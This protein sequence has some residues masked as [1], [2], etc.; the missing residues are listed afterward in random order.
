MRNIPH[1]VH[2]LEH[3]VP[4]VKLFGE[5]VECLGGGALL[6][7]RMSFEAGLRMYSPAHFQFS[8][9]PVCSADVSSQIPAPATMPPV[10]ML[11]KSLW[12]LVLWN[13]KLK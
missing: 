11:L 9:H 10:A 8:L 5:M 3:L 12:T 6:E 13:C 7:K 2:V 4:L 1:G